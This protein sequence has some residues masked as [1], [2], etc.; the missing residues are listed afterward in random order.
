MGLWKLESDFGN[1]KI[2]SGNWFW[3]IGKY[4]L[5]LLVETNKEKWENIFMGKEIKTFQDLI[6]YQNL[7]QAI[8]LFLQK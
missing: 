3:K 6:V 4:W 1:Y 8:K 2:D 5:K 7:Y